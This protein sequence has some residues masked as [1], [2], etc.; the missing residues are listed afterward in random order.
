MKRIM[1]LF[2]AVILTIGAVFISGCNQ[3]GKTGNP[4][5]IQNEEGLRVHAI[6]DSDDTQAWHLWQSVHDEKFMVENPLEKY[7]FLPTSAGEETVDIYNAYS[8][9][10]VLNGVSI[11]PH[12]TK[13]VTYEINHPY[14]VN[15]KDE[16]I[17]LTFMKS[18]AEAA[19]FINND[20]VDGNGTDLM[21]YLN[22]ERKNKD[23]SRTA[24][25]TGAILDADG[26][27]DNTSIKKI[28]GRGNTSWGKSKKSYN[29]T[30][31]NAV[32]VAG[33]KEGKKYSLVANY[34]D[35]S[36]SRN[37]F[38]YDLSDAVGVPYASDSRYTDLYVNGYYCGSYQMCEKIDA[39]K[40]SLVND[41]KAAD[42]LSADGTIK[43]DFP[44][45]CVVDPSVNDNDDYYVKTDGGIITIKYPELHK[46]DAGYDEV[47]NYVAEKYNQLF[48]AA[49]S[50]K[51][52]LS[53]CGDLNSLA[54]LFL[55]NELGKNWDSGVSSLYFV[56]KPDAE[57]QYK[58]F[59]SPVWDYD[60]SLGNAAGV[61]AELKYINVSDY[62]SYTGWWCKYK[63]GSD[64]IVNRLSQNPEIMSAAKSVWFEQFVPA[65]NH[66]SGE[67]SSDK[68]DSEIYTSEKYYSLIK[69]SAEMN[70]KSG[71]LL[72]TSGW[73]AD[74]SSL[75]K[76][77]FDE[78]SKTMVTDPTASA[79][80]A[81]F[82][83]MYNYCTDWMVSRAAWISQEFSN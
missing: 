20:N 27:I 52:D 77:H 64:N 69:D 75:T 48:A 79:Y 45:L 68:L 28:K 32:S 37:R 70:Y 67:D 41:I 17:T 51:N 76:A 9:A 63:G 34:Q 71:W 25:A 30:Y 55:I 29:V 6:S 81:D 7:F 47:K 62:T 44:F 56:Y 40:N 80:N 58:F 72:N 59:G 74:H 16:T 65:I 4:T 38:L 43:K 54:K 82:T 46:G 23:K 15:V 60:N 61:D 31:R 39:G 14:E 10:V 13:A 73:I 42:Y 66:F 3:I 5:T 18:N 12:T 8:E 49:A 21:A 19:I 1:S 22:D 11:E 33:M 2:L 78:Q 57:G 26:N 83:G 35:D 53:A 50:D 24:A 36:L